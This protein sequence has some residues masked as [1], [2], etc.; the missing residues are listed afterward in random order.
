MKERSDMA[1]INGDEYAEWFEHQNWVTKL[2]ILIQN[3]IDIIK[4]W[5]KRSNY[6]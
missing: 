2:G 3:I 5:W 1:W 6:G 4:H